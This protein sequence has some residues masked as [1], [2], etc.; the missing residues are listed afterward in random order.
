M[1]N[2]TISDQYFQGFPCRKKDICNCA[3]FIQTVQLQLSFVE[4]IFKLP[5]E[6]SLI[7]NRISYNLQYL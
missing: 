4:I 1:K 2:L 5:V 3:V 6:I 7:E